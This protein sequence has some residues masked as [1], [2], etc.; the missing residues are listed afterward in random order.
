MSIFNHSNVGNPNSSHDGAEKNAGSNSSLVHEKSQIYQ[1]TKGSYQF[2]KMAGR[3]TEN[4]M[5]YHPSPHENRFIKKKTF[6]QIKYRFE[7]G[8]II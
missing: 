8:L 6:Y 4:F 7:A 2:G 3:S 5:K 1:K